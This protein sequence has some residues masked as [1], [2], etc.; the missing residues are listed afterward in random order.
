LA[1]EM[2]LE[3]FHFVRSALTTVELPSEIDGKLGMGCEFDVL[4]GT[5]VV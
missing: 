2:A 4:N 1:G 3:K 5:H